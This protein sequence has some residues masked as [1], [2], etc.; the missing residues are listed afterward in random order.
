[1]GE[2]KKGVRIE[3]GRQYGVITVLSVAQDR[4]R[5]YNCRCG[6]CGNIFTCSGQEVYKNQGTGCAGCRKAY[7]NS[8]KTYELNKAYC[9]KKYGDLTVTSVRL[10][11]DG[12]Y[13]YPRNKPLAL[14]R[15]T[16]GRE[17]EIPLAR[18][19][20]GGARTCG[21]GTDK[22]FKI[23]REMVAKASVA[24]TNVLCIQPT[25]QVNRNSTTGI[26]GVSKLANGK[27]RAYICFQRKQY[28]LGT[29][30]DIGEAK[31]AR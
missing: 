1:M 18:I 19:L 11:W 10:E 20:Q 13:G 30:D 15:C 3:I 21:H 4:P 27:Y 9:G 22:N 24:G 8:K 2:R 26:K 5:K 25:R 6:K 7:K 31:E 16:C 12:N 28:H 17:K 23:G 29:Y 14:C